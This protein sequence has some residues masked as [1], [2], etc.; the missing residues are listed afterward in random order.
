MSRWHPEVVIMDARMPV[1]DGFEATRQIKERWP[2]VRV[3]MLTMHPG[4]RAEALSAG[5]DGYLLKGCTM[6][7]LLEAIAGSGGPEPSPGRDGRPPVPQPGFPAGSEE[8]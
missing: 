6:Q 2:V 3:V 5:A 7:K 8:L 4:G 1:M